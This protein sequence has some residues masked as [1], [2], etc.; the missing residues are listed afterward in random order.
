MVSI[1]VQRVFARQ[2]RLDV[3]RKNS[4]S[5]LCLSLAF[6]SASKKS[7]PAFESIGSRSALLETGH[8]HFIMQFS[9]F[10]GVCSLGPSPLKRLCLT[11]I[12]LIGQV[13][14]RV[15]NSLVC[16]FCRISQTLTACESMPC[17]AIA[18][19]HFR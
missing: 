1:A 13:T 16:Q 8:S 2:S 3:S 14:D 18:P 4:K 6:R 11:L 17:C 15:R 9:S 5:S 19:L 10:Q 12:R 7:G